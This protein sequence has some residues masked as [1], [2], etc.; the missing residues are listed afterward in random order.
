[1]KLKNFIHPFLF[2]IFPILFIFAYNI[3][4]VTAIDLIAP[5]LVVI[6]GTV[7]LML[8]F[9]LITKSYGKSAIA[10]SLS[11]ILFF[12]YGHARNLLLSAGITEL[13]HINHLGVQNALLFIWVACFAIGAF[14]VIKTRKN[15]SALTTFLNIA[16]T[17]LV[18]I[19]LGTIG[20]Y[21]IGKPSYTT[22]EVKE[23]CFDKGNPEKLPDI[24]YIILDAYAR[25]DTLQEV[26]GY[27]NTEFINYLIGKGFYVANKS[28]SNYD[29]TADSLASS[30]N[31][32]Y[33]TEEESNIH[34]T[35]VNAMYYNE[36]FRILKGKGYYYIFISGGREYSTDYTD[37]Y[38]SY[39]VLS[40]LRGDSIPRLLL[41]T[42]LLAPF[43]WYLND[44]IDDHSRQSRLFAFD[45]LANIPYI[46]A[47]TFTYSH[48]V[49]PHPLYLFDREG[50]PA[51]PDMSIFWNPSELIDNEEKYI[52]QLIFT[53]KKTMVLV[54]EII[55]RSDI[56]PIII[57][58][59]DHGVWWGDGIGNEILNAYYLP[60][61][62]H[63]LYETISPVNSFRVVFNLYFDA[64]YELLKDESFETGRWDE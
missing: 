12:S 52:D 64:N 32:R 26:F 39:N 11:L 35:R 41:E 22:E 4:E 29:H 50:N 28:E 19:S 49:L 45:E 6:A 10:T 43:T 23:V 59:G 30:L 46:E 51:T 62:E 16:I 57:I 18:I 5:I 34:K 3:E 9:R 54:D 36:A 14:L 42:T 63:N 7:A 48:I 40:I 55:T 1:M 44:F 53:N 47:P 21:E 13:F 31:M 8:L 61:V 60:G 24:Y 2:A 58:Q 37:L 33:L 17:I 15:L 27:D 56:A 20:I 38:L 25:Q